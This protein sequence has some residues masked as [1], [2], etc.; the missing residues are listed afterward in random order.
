MCD[1]PGRGPRVFGAISGREGG[2]GGGLGLAGVGGNGAP[3]PPGPVGES[4]LLSRG[5]EVRR[6]RREVRR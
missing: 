3:T 1:S 2:G 6:A 5:A 4:R